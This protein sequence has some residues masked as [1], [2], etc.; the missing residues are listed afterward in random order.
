MTPRTV[1]PASVGG[2][3]AAVAVRMRECQTEIEQAV[4]A[5]SETLLESIRGL[6]PEYMDAQRAAVGAAVA[7]GIDAIEFGEA[8]C[9]EVPAVF[10]AQARLTARSSVSLDMMMRRYFAGYV[11]LGDFLMREAD[12]CSL[13]GAALQCIMRDTAAVFDR[14]ISTIAEE[15]QREAR[16]LLTSAEERRAARVR[17]LLSGELMDAADIDYEFEEWH[18]GAV[19]AGEG[20]PDALRDLAQSLDRRLLQVPSDDDVVWA[21]FG[22]RR[23]VEAETLEDV[24]SSVWPEHL[25]LALGE[26]A[27][28]LAG[29]RLTHRQA[30]AVVPVARR[31]GSGWVQYADAAL[32][33]SVLQDDL[34]IGSLQERYLAPL[35][36]D[37]DGGETL[38]ATLRAFFS[39]DR[40]VSSAAAM[41]GVNRHTVTNRLRIVEERI[42]RSLPPRAPRSKPPFGCRTWSSQAEAETNE[43]IRACWR[44]RR[45]S[46]RSM[47][48]RSSQRRTAPSTKKTQPCSAVSRSGVRSTL[49][50][51]ASQ[52][53][54]DSIRAFSR[55]WRFC[56]SVASISG[57]PP[58]RL[59]KI[60][61]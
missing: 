4:R 48:R 21:W 26:S 17:A 14:L 31:N 3:R 6:D 1:A 9:R 54:S 49:T 18:L 32:L 44:S 41:L 57:S 36:S 39:S 16:G 42:G 23:P 45:S 51:A 55:S 29:W 19:A 24:L 60:A 30:Q 12:Q 37:R 33:A 53:A 8:R 20:A 10:H 56:S 5:R 13:N 47:S 15:Y 11:L 27:R 58:P 50:G 52:L 59:R 46:P 28:G 38:R 61:M 43:S 25:S 40:N 35:A 7:Y 34:L 22:G 2:Q